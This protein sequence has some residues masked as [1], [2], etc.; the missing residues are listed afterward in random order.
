M[1]DSFVMND[2]HWRVK[3]VSPSNEH[4]VD[5]TNTLTVATTEPGTNTVYLSSR[6]HGEFLTRVF[7]HELGHCAMVSYG[8]LDEIHKAVEPRYRVYIEEWICNFIADYGLGIFQIAYRVL[9][10]K[11]WEH[12]PDEITKLIA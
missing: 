5:R 12:I 9:G 10:E 2:R 8:L 1:V 6:L 11:A 4:L 3:F 7:L